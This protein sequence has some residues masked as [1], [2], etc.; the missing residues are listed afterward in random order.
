MNYFAHAIS[1][2]DRPYFAAGTGVPDWLSVCDRSVRLRGKHVE[3]FTPGE[4][5]QAAEVVGGILR[6]IRD[7]RVF[8]QSRPFAE[9]SLKLTVEARDALEPD[10][11][12]R[13][14]FLGH[15]LV[16]VLLDASLAAENP[17]LLDEY[18]RVMKSVDAVVVESTVNRIGPRRTDRL[19]VM[20]SRFLQE[21]ILYDYLEDAKLMVRLNQVM[22]RVKLPLLPDGFVEVL[23]RAREMVQRHREELLEGIF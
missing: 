5:R 18:Y 8:H 22:R 7:D 6:H 4:D 19:A 17:H 2:L 9:L 11:G 16:E 10:A 15:L 3:A 12:F 23:P 14:G 21:R 20:I 1:F 13:P